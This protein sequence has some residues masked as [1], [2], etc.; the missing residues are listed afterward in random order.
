M[1]TYRKEIYGTI[2]F[3]VLYLLV[4]H[5]AV[6]AIIFGTN[7]DIRVL[8]FPVHYFLAIFLG[9]FGVMAV[10]IWWTRFTEALDAEIECGESAESA[11]IAAVVRD[12]Q[13]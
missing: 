2:F 11:P 4:A 1:E 10:A 6:W 7:N 12:A 13:P 3:F 5:T 9:W 8:G